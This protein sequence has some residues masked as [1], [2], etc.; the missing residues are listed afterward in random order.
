MRGADSDAGELAAHRVCGAVFESL[1]E[2]GDRRRGWVGDKQVHVVGF[3]VEFDQLTM[4]FDAQYGAHGVLAEA[5]HLVGRHPPA[6]F[7]HEH[8][9]RLKRRDVVAGAAMGLGCR[10]S[11]L[12]CGCADA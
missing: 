5:K 10:W 6:V 1:D 12:R 11:A 4:E 9:I 7:G 3:V 2:G 8:Q